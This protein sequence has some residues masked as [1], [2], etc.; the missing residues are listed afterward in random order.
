M[1]LVSTVGRKS[2][3]VRF[4]FIGIYIL[5]TVGAVS[6]AYPLLLV[7]TMATTGLADHNEF[8]LLP[9]YWTSDAAL[10]RKYLVDAAEMDDLAVWF[11][12]DRWFNPKDISEDDLRPVME[13]DQARRKAMASD[14]S[15]FIS[16]KCPS[17]FKLSIFTQDVDSPIAQQSEYFGWLEN[18][19]GRI[20]KINSAYPDNAEIWE[21]VGMPQNQLQRRPENTPRSRDYRKFVESRPPQRT[22]LFSAELHLFLF[23]RTV[24]VPKN[25][26]KR[27]THVTCED[28]A[29]GKLGGG[30]WEQFLRTKAPA[31]FVRVDTTIALPAWKSFIAA[32]GEDAST[33]LA[34]RIPLDKRMAGLWGQFVRTV[35]PVKAMSLA[36][37]EES[38]RRFLKARY[39]GIDA[40]NRAYGAKYSGF[41]EV[42]IPYA[43]FH[44]D[45]FTRIQKSLRWRYL[46]HNFAAVISFAAIH[47]R[48]LWVTLAYILLAVL[49][50]LTVNPLAAY[51]M[52]RFRLRETYHVL[53]FL[54]A[55]MAFP[56][57]VLMIPN[58]LL[59]KEFPLL[60]IIA[61]GVCILG[62]FL[63]QRKLGRGL[64]MMVKFVAALVVTL[65]V[66]G[67]AVPQ[68]A[69]MLHIK[70]SVTL[71]NSFWALI[72]PS[73]ASG[74]GIFLL[75]GFFDSLPPELY[76]AGLIDGASELRM[77]WKITLPL[78][79]P[80]LAV[81]ALGAFTTA[82][83]AFMHAFLVC[84]DPKMW[85]LMV[86]LY[87]FQ[88]LH[89]VP[90]AMASLV[91]AAIPTLL[92]FVFCQNIIL[93]GI[94]IPTYK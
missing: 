36:R 84:Q 18:R 20:E 56:A 60:Q 4:L 1:P 55:T 7:T 3:R 33:H 8:R 39:G 11:G 92:V 64:P 87:E 15:R 31:R 79:K 80:I 25:Y 83:G 68:A 54:L 67:W 69:G 10:F 12:Q 65:A 76:E 35:C 5:L 85:T 24:S 27:L 14:V 78:C 48:A 61:L 47:G 77:F 22:G 91:I 94:V 37:P 90:M 44:Y 88:Q 70:S 2:P 71:M 75:K 49:T 16:K 9:A 86:F 59:I 52:S 89:S 26:S 74:Y 66:V 82:Y 57:E 17:E 28:V 38:W 40:L 30:L 73:M 43:A 51:A 58:F 50:T 23:L 6:M 34:E 21:D 32:K 72:L 13:M 81:L 45:N 46:G 62:F 63:L 93:R 41:D 19:Y 42:R 53:V 29:A